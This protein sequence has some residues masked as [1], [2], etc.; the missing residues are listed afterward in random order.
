M[1][2]KNS[3][4]IKMSSSP[5]SSTFSSP[6]FTASADSTTSAM[7][8]PETFYNDIA[9]VLTL[10]GVKVSD[11]LDGLSIVCYSRD[12]DMN[13]NSD[14]RIQKCRGL[15]YD[16]SGKLISHA[17]GYTPMFTLADKSWAVEPCEDSP[18]FKDVSEGFVYL[19]EHLKKY[20]KENKCKIY[21]S[22]EGCLVRVFNHNGKWYTTTHR[23]LDAFKSYWGCRTSFG[24][25]FFN[26]LETARQTQPDFAEKFADSENLLESF[27][28]TLN[29][30]HQ[31]V[32][33]VSSCSENRI[34]C[35]PPARQYAIHVATFKNG[36][37]VQDTVLG[38][39]SQTP[40]SHLD[41]F[42][43]VV[44][45]ICSL[46]PFVYQGVV[47]FLPNGRQ[48]KICSPQYTSFY[49]LR[50]NEAS[51]MFRYLQV[52]TKYMNEFVSLYPEYSERFQHYE[53]MILKIGQKI[54]ETYK[55]RFVRQLFLKTSPEEFA[56][57]STAH[58][59][60]KNSCA[61]KAKQNVSLEHILEI[62]NS[63]P[64]TNINKMIRKLVADEK[65]ELKGE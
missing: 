36:E 49:N 63:Q 55:A 10:P 30:E 29:P 31:Y 40:I 8:V 17:F 47:V 50:G 45:Y 16:E 2:E 19:P 9:N 26:C 23:K 27:Y 57:M 6:S 21:P 65:K 58:T 52:R 56:V 11:T 7:S 12:Y 38:I 24:E 13:H 41:D 59:N 3:A 62:L 43:D 53:D 32:F 5:A 15:V 20:M 60:F 14:E 4:K 18:D 42:S 22:I 35:H 25:M 54:L 44:D 33:L 28:T 61:N 1:D 39:P 64:A 51:V 48:F 34:V 46:D 37:E